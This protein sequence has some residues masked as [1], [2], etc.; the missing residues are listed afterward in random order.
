MFYCCITNCLIKYAIKWYRK[1][2]GMELKIK[3]KAVNDTY[4]IKYSLRTFF[5]R[6]IFMECVYALLHENTKQCIISFTFDSIVFKEQC[7]SWKT[8]SESYTMM[9]I[10]SKLLLLWVCCCFS[11]CL[12]VYLPAYFMRRVLKNIKKFH[13]DLFSPRFFFFWNKGVHLHFRII[14]QVR[15]SFRLTK[16]NKSQFI[17]SFYLKAERASESEW[18]Y[19]LVFQFTYQEIQVWLLLFQIDC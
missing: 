6:N 4:Y 16:E 9:S 11:I 17:F 18:V 15:F 10:N 19:V 12:F 7:I 3:K 1:F 14:L 13:D 5:S 8:L 2:S